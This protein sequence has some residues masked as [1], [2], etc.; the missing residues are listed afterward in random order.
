MVGEES[1]MTSVE[2]HVALAS[3]RACLRACNL[4]VTLYMGLPEEGIC[5]VF[6]T[7]GG[8]YE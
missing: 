8:R 5:Q 1:S 7:I 4:D 3:L 6:L 2:V